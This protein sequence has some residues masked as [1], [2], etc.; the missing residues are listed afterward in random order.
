MT[1]EPKVSVILP[2][3]NAEKYLAQAIE[4]ILNQSYHNFELLLLNDGSQD[5]SLE[6]ATRF[7][8]KD[9]RIQI[10]SH[11]T[12]LGLIPSLNTLLKKVSPETKYI[13]RMDADDW[14]HTDR[15]KKQVAFLENNPHFVG[16]GSNMAYVDVEGNLLQNSNLP[17]NYPEILVL[18]LFT[19]PFCHP[20]IL[21]KK[22]FWLNTQNNFF[23]L[24]NFPYAEDYELFSRML[25]QGAFCNLPEVLY[26]YRRHT[27]SICYQHSDLQL[28]SLKLIY[29]QNLQRL[30]LLPT[31]RELALHYQLT[32]N[33]KAESFLEIKHIHDWL[34]K[35]WQANQRKKI[36]PNQELW[37][38]I[39]NIWLKF[40]AGKTFL[41][42][43]F[44]IFFAKSRFSV[45]QEWDIW[46]KIKFWIKCLLK[47]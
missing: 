9:N 29:Q 7:Q 35:L 27:E 39:K 34:N 17:Q 25:L 45:Y 26:F 46:Q 38:T 28:N 1:L 30:D 21:V 11:A 23:Y 31:E 6:I 47:V 4:S 20:S 3:Y 2:F 18:S 44:G 42:L 22:S 8:S 41:G 36:Y 40:T 24:S 16:C 5:N 19:I 14:C 15:L 12:N 13:A 10:Y 37:Q 43:Q 33:Y 32:R